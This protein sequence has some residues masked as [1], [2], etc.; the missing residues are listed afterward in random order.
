MREGRECSEYHTYV[1]LSIS[2]EKVLLI[3][4]TLALGVGDSFSSLEIIAGLDAFPPFFKHG[5]AL[6]SGIRKKTEI[7]R[8][9]H[10]HF[11]WLSEMKAAGLTLA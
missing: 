8:I 6:S 5:V 7:D 2:E 1:F 10:V 9:S 4:T 11:L 3:F